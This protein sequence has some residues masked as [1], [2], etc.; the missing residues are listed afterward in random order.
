LQSLIISYIKGEKLYI[1]WIKID[2]TLP[3]IE[4]RGE[5]QTR[6]EAKKA[7]KQILGNVKVEIVNASIRRDSIKALA[8]T[9]ARR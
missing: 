1:V 6:R 2:E 3:K 9:R 8:T 4:L 7:A 5:Y